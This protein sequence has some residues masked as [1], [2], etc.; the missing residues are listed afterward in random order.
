[1]KKK[2]KK[3]AVLLAVVLLAT[4]M[5]SLTA[6]AATQTE[7]IEIETR[8]IL[9]I[10]KSGS[11]KDQQAV[12]DILDQYDIAS[13]DA[14][15]WFDHRISDDPEFVGGGDSHICE[16]VD[17]AADGGFTHITVVTD[18]E[19]WPQD[20]SA[21]GLYSDLDLTIHLVEEDKIAVAEELVSKLEV[22]LEKS[23][24]K[25]VKPDGTEESLSNDYQSPVYEVKFEI[26]DAPDAELEETVKDSKCHWLWALL[27]AVLIAALFDLIHELITRRKV[28]EEDKTTDNNA[29]P[30]P[31]PTMSENTVVAVTEKLRESDDVVEYYIDNSTS[32]ERVFHGAAEAARR[33]GTKSATTF[34]SEVKERDVS[35]L[36]ALTAQGQTKGW[37]ALE[38]T[39]GRRNAV[40]L[41]DMQFNG[42]VFDESAFA[43]KH[44]RKVTVFAPAGYNAAEVENL[45]KI[46]DEVEVLPL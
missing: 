20:Y 14:V 43:G 45:K 28:K 30:A 19:Q 40:I 34:G 2:I 18:G 26:P 36:A 27:L 46:A 1:M 31:A 39:K 17:K 8:S 37:E 41:S 11:M 12:E 35:E 7:R 29:A 16:A 6:A 23:N 33:S 5:V 24:L 13:Y 38:T 25:V 21:L 22:A 10:D 42:K 44:F 3:T 9:L 4:M 32:F 15:R